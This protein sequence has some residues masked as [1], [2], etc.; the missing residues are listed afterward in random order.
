MVL[1][2]L[3]LFFYGRKR[4]CRES[5]TQ[6]ALQRPQYTQVSWLGELVRLQQA[7]DWVNAC[8]CSVH[9]E[10]AGGMYDDPSV[11]AAFRRSSSGAYN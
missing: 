4:N 5:T 11:T 2:F 9:V 6:R 8:A 7:T 3:W 1:S 10:D